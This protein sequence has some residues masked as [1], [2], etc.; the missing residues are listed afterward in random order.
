MKKIALFSLLLMAF[1]TFAFEKKH[2]F[3]RAN[4]SATTVSSDGFNGTNI[5]GGLVPSYGLKLGAQLHKNFS[6][7]GGF[8]THSDSENNLKASFFNILSEL[9]Y[10]L[11]SYGSLYMGPRLGI[12]SAKT[13]SNRETGLLYGVGLGYNF[14][15]GERFTVGIDRNYTM[16]KINSTDVKFFDLG[17]TGSFLF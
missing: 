14:P 9:N 12:A 13:N 10:H 1:N 4:L 15:I 5:Y 17:I 2:G 8:Q 3:V 16:T 6:L 7:A 11:D